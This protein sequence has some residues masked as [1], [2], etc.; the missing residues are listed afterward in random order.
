MRVSTPLVLIID[1]EPG[2]VRLFSSLIERINYTTIQADGG[3]AALTILDETTP[4]LMILDLAMPDVSGIEVLQHVRRIPRLNAMKIMILTARPNMVP[5]V[6]ALGIDS[7]LTKPVMPN[8]FLA[9][10]RELVTEE[11]A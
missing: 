6:E 9:A 3:L 1:D 4:N 5:E 2:L 11:Q 10:V 8:D 7:W